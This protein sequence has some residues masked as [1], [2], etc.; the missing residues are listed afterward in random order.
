MNNR[1]RRQRGGSAL[2][3][4]LLLPWYFFLFVGTF[5]WG[6][7]A[8]ALISTEAAARTA[9]LYTSQSVATASDQADACTL[10]NEE[11]RIVPNISNS[12]ATTCTSSP[13]SVT[14]VQ[15][16]VGQTVG[17]ADNLP[18]SQVSVTYTTLSLI[19]IPF[20][21]A[22]KATFVRVAQMRLRCPTC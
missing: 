4:A 16:G 3:M 10:A 21:L 15:A 20:V 2:E 6:F 1:R 12:D 14:A 9:V 5:D 22:N 13:L 19:P 18:A 11:M 17:S 7:Y 8:H